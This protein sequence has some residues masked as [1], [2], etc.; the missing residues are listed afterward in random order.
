MAYHYFDHDADIGI[1]GIG[2]SLPEAFAE[3]A[4]AMF[5]VMADLQT[6]RPA[7]SISVRCQARSREEL[8]VAWLNALLAESEARHL[9]LCEF[10]VEQLSDT[11][12][13]SRAR[14]EPWD[15]ARHRLKAEVKAATYCMAEVVQ[16]HDAYRCQCVI[17]I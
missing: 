6:V 12:L 9:G 17:D 14:G 3:A 7:R 16:E 5:A 15:P 4:R 8:L 1:V 2:R 10:H 11:A 13:R